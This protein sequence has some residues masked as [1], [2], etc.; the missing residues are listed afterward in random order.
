MW[1]Q[2]SQFHRPRSFSHSLI[3]KTYVVVFSLLDHCYVHFYCNNAPTPAVDFL[4]VCTL[5]LS[6]EDGNSLR[7]KPPFL[8]TDQ[9]GCNRAGQPNRRSHRAPR[10]FNGPII[11][12][13]LEKSRVWSTYKQA[14][15][16]VSRSETSRRDFRIT[17]TADDLWQTQ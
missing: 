14:T 6:I 8:W 1:L 17:S 9:L 13:L 11:L 16:R 2:K 10:Y 4:G 3:S 15:C 5:V 7:Q 12:N